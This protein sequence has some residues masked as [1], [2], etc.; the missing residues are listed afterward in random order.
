MSNKKYVKYILKGGATEYDKNIPYILN[1][2]NMVFDN[3]LTR[4]K[5]CLGEMKMIQTKNEKQK[6]FL[7]FTIQTYSSN[8]QK[9]E[10]SD[11]YKNYNVNKII[12]NKETRELKLS[13]G[14][15]LISEQDITQHFQKYYF[16]LVQY[17]LKFAIDLLTDVLKKAKDTKVPIFTIPSYREYLKKNNITS[18]EKQ[19]DNKRVTILDEDLVCVLEEG[20]SNCYIFNIMQYL[21]KFPLLMRELSGKMKIDL[22][23]M[24]SIILKYMGQINE[25]QRSNDDYNKQFVGP[26]S[27]R[28]TSKKFETFVKNPLEIFGNYKEIIPDKKWSPITK[29]SE[30]PKSPTLIIGQRKPPVPEREPITLDDVAMPKRDDVNRPLPPPPPPPKR[31]PITIKDVTPHKRPLPPPP[32][33]EPITPE[34]VTMPPIISKSSPPPSRPVP[35]PPSSNIIIPTP[36]PPPLPASTVPKKVIPITSVSSESFTET[37]EKIESMQSPSSPEQPSKQNLLEAIR[38]KR[39]DLVD[40]SGEKQP[41]VERVIVKTSPK[42]EITP[43]KKSEIIQEQQKTGLTL[44]QGLQNKFGK[45][46]GTPCDPDSIKRECKMGLECD[47][48]QKIC[49]DQDGGKKYT[50]I[51]F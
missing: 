45:D 49:K 16:P 18:L 9:I 29:R 8:I 34:D 14:K 1:E 35:L 5:C 23:N 37:K 20:S 2:F 48:K 50:K 43:E 27:S 19:V 13:N 39:K 21:G 3:I 12:I 10:N 7:D 31:E 44:F 42:K 51:Y 24:S 47:E 17:L 46:E 40:S 38:A 11:V 32:K 30:S 41:D 15:I 6:Q 22:T 33:R 26:I 25:L 36:P 4:L 28:I